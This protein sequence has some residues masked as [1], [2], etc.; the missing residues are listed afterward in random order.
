MSFGN[1]QSKKQSRIEE[2]EGII[3]R[4]SPSFSV[5]LNF[6]FDFERMTKLPLVF[7]V[8]LLAQALGARPSFDEKNA[9]E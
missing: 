4:P 3:R 9:S 8:Y 2:P 6:S 1:E 5:A 7:F